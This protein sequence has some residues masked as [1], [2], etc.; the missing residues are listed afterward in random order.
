MK[1]RWDKKQENLWPI[2]Y[3]TLL[4]YYKNLDKRYQFFFDKFKKK[5]IIIFFEFRPF[6]ATTKPINFKQFLDFNEIDFI[7]NCEVNSI[8]ENN[9]RVT[10]YCSDKNL[11]FTP[12][13]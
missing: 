12:K 10:V 8:D 1:S 6:F 13:R 3:K 4:K 2:S 5:K 7:Y 9:K 11:D